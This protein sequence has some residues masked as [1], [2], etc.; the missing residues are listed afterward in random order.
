MSK[1]LVLLGV[2]ALSVSSTSASSDHDNVNESRSA[3]DAQSKAVLSQSRLVKAQTDECRDRITHAR[4]A[5]GQSPVLER[6]P[7]SPD[8]PYAIY[9]VHREQ[10]GCSVMVMMG[11]REDIR[12]LPTPMEEPLT[13]IPAETDQ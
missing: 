12:P 13:I 10:D 2:A 6:E 8:R 3:Q 1:V 7:A 5:S 9:A 11:N 4:E